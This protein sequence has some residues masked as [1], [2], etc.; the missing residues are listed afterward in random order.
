MKKTT[1]GF[2]NP[3]RNDNN[4]SQ[5]DSM[6][7]KECWLRDFYTLRGTSVIKENASFWAKLLS[8]DP[9]FGLVIG[10]STVYHSEES[11][12]NALKSNLGVLHYLNPFV[13]LSL[14]SLIISIELNKH[15]G[16]EVLSSI[17]YYLFALPLTILGLVSQILFTLAHAG[18]A[19]LL[20]TCSAGINQ[21]GNLMEAEV[22]QSEASAEGD[23]SLSLQA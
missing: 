7:F 22:D 14:I 5:T 8:V 19:A 1:Y 18:L 16:F 2:F 17:N 10:L 12:P 23:E 9:Y 15:E 6:S 11:K 21:L 13:P 3:S 20:A 4:N